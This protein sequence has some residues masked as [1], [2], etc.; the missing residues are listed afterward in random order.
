MTRIKRAS[1]ISAFAIAGWMALSSAAWADDLSLASVAAAIAT[2][3]S[4]PGPLSVG[5]VRVDQPLLA[6]AYGMRQNK[7]VWLDDTGVPS[8]A[9]QAAL[10][11]IADASA[12]GLNPDAYHLSALQGMAKPVTAADSAGFDLLLSDSIVSYLH[13]LATGRTPVGQFDRDSS[14]PDMLRT[15][16]ASSPPS[17]PCSPSDL[18]RYAEAS[19]PQEP[20]YAALKK[21]L[22]DLRQQQAAGGWTGPVRTGPALKPGMSNPVLPAL[23]RAPVAAAGPGQGR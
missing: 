11:L 21:A 5:Q 12:N 16:P 15:N 14:F 17:R 23:A 3:L 1:Y 7:P 22:A 18:R 19:V 8:P 4:A 13:D 6:S 10:A 20:D 9:S 2:V